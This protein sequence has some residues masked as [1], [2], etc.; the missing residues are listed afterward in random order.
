MYTYTLHRWP[1][2]YG[3]AVAALRCYS[4]STTQVNSSVCGR[5]ATK[6]DLATCEETEKFCYVEV[7]TVG[8]V[9]IWLERG[10]TSS[11]AGTDTCRSNGDGTGVCRDCCQGDGCNGGVPNTDWSGPG[12]A[13]TSCGGTFLEDSGTVST[14]GYPD[15]YPNN[16]N[17]EFLFP[18]TG[19]IVAVK[20]KDF[21]M[22][23]RDWLSRCHDSIMVYAHNKLVDEYCGEE[24]PGTIISYGVRI[25]FMSD[26]SVSKSG[27]TLTYSRTQGLES[28]DDLG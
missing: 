2:D 12:N 26:Y 4:C 27:F 16:L 1:R 14:P 24:D 20:F 17:C 11:C 6:T 15:N 28:T 8:S 19:Q 10:C 22:E 3:C 9:P 23:G 18:D 13:V 5:R 7:V 25:V 21:H